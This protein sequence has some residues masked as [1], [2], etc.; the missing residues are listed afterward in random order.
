MIE[1]FG[2]QI[3]YPD[4]FVVII[5]TAAL[6]SGISIAI[7]RKLVDPKRMEEIRKKIEEHQ[8]RYLEAQKSG[9]KKE[10]QKLEAEQEEIM[11]L[12]KEN[13][14]N[15]FKPMFITTPI[16]L[17]IIWMFGSMYGSLGAI[18]NLPFGLPILT[19]PFPEMGVQNGIDWLG[20]YIV[21][22]IIISLTLQLII[23]RI[24]K[25]REQK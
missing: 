16:V 3:I 24:D 4:V 13:M 1:I 10:L 12:V 8:K 15:S 18:I 21:S 9:D 7:H 11:A 19:R 25:R 5:F 22:A 6:L 17:F 2:L 23:K 20:L 14:Y